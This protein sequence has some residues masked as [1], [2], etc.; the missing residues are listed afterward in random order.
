MVDLTIKRDLDPEVQQLAEDIRAA[1]GP[2]VETLSDWLAEWGEDVPE[3][4]RDHVNA[5]HDNDDMSGDMGGME[6]SDSDMPGM[7]SSDDLQALEEAPDADFQTMW[8]DMMIEHHEG[9]VEMSETEVQ[10]GQYKPAVDLAN[11]IIRSQ[12]EQVGTMQQM[13]GS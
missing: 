11:S 10:D 5:G 6:E 7:M 4:L 8:L 13:L 9:A 1:Q 12:T 2:E 3:T